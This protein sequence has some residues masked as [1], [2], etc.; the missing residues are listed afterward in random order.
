M[1]KDKDKEERE[2]PGGQETMVDSADQEKNMEEENLSSE[3]EE[4]KENENLEHDKAGKK[5]PKDVQIEEMQ[6]RL[7]RQ[8]AEFDNFRKRTEKEK[9]AMY[10][11]GAREMIEKILPVLDNFERALAAVPEE[12]KGSSFAEGVEMI[13]KQFIKTLED[14][15]VEMIEAVGQQF[16]PDVHNAVMH[17]ED[18]AYGENEISQELQ[19]GYKYRGTVVRHSMVQVAN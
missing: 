12:E 14:A 18:E 16:N 8:M 1:G 10:E 7:M 17:I 19:K 5:D 6:D 13:Y 9:S 4:A 11:V 3:T 2:T 15:G